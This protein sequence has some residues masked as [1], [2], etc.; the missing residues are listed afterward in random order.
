[1]PYNSAPK[2]RTIVNVGR[3]WASLQEAADYLG[4]HERTVRK[5]GADG[6]LRLYRKGA[7]LVRVDLNEVDAML[8]AAP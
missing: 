4:V 6:R 7:R 5:M 1:V 2:R 3:R 8:G